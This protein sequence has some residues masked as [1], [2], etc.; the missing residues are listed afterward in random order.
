MAM[1]PHYVVAEPSSSHPAVLTLTFCAT[2]PP[3]SSVVRQHAP[4]SRLIHGT[5]LT[6]STCITTTACLAMVRKRQQDDP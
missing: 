4:C 5:T 3:S 6:F 1:P 2:S